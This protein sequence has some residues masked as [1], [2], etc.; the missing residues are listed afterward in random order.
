MWMVELVFLVDAS[1]SVGEQNFA[2]ELRF[3]KKLLADFTVSVNDTRVAVI[4]YASKDQ[5]TVN[6]DHI[7]AASEANHKCSLLQE[8]LPSVRYSGGGTYTLGALL[9]AQAV[10]AGA[11]PTARRA[12]FLVTD[13]FSNGGDPRPA[14]RRLRDSGA[15]VFTFGVRSG[16]TREL[17]DMAT[18]PAA[19]H[20]FLLDGFG[21]FAALAR[22]ALHQDLKPG[23]YVPLGDSSPCDR[24]CVEKRDCCDATASCSCGVDSGHYACVC[25]P[26]H[27]GSGLARSCKAC[28]NGTYSDGSVPGDESVCLPCPDAN[29]VTL[30][31]ATSQQQCRCKEGFV[32]HG[33]RCEVITCPELSP[34]RHGFFVK[35]SCGNVLNAACGARCRVGYRLAGSSIRLCQHDGTW[36][37]EDA[38]CIVKKCPP[39]VLPPNGNMSCSDPDLVVDTE[40]RFACSP[41]HLLVGSKSR[42]CLPLSRWDGLQTICKPLQCPALPQLA[43]GAVSPAA[44][45]AGKQAYGAVC[46]ATCRQGYQLKGPPSRTCGGRAGVWSGKSSNNRCVDATP[47]ELRCPGDIVVGNDPGE[48][49]A[50]VSWSVPNATDNSGHKPVVWSKPSVVP[51]LKM[52]I[53]TTVITYTASDSSKNKAKCNFT[54]TVKDREP[55]AVDQ[56][57]EP[58]PFLTDSA[59][60]ELAWDE[61]QFHDNSGEPVKIRRSPEGD[62]FD[63]GSTLVT[64]TVSDDAGNNSTCSFNVTVEENVCKSPPDL[65]NGHAN[66]SSSPD[67]LHCTLTC[68][69]G[70]AVA[71]Q[72]RDFF[73]TYD[74]AGLVLAPDLEVDPFPDCSVTVLPNSISQDSV[75]TLSGEETLCED[76]GFLSQLEPAMKENIAEKLQQICGSSELV[77]Q[78]GDMKAACDQILSSIE[79]ESNAIPRR[80]RRAVGAGPAVV[81]DTAESNISVTFQI[82]GTASKSQDAGRMLVN[83]IRHVKEALGPALAR[84]GSLQVGPRKRRLRVRHF[85]T[86]GEPRVSCGLGSV[87][88]R[89]K[90]VKCPMGTHH[91]VTSDSCE[92]CGIGEYQP[93]EGEAAC[94]PCPAGSS[95]RKINAKNIRDCRAL[96]PPGC[97][98]RKKRLSLDVPGIKPCAS[99]QLGSYQTLHGQ[100]ACLPCPEN[101]T[102]LRRGAK[103]HSDCKERCPPDSASATGLAPCLA[104]PPGHRQPA[105]GQRTCEDAAGRRVPFSPCFSSPCQRGGTCRALGRQLFACDCPDGYQGSL[106]EEEVDSCE[107]SP[108]LHGGTCSSHGPSYTCSCPPGFTGLS[109]ETDVDECESSPCL[110]GGS[111][112]DSL[113]EYVCLCA[114][115]FQGDR[116]EEDTDECAALPC[117]NE[118]LCVDGVATYSCE[119]LPGFAGAHCEE[120][121]ADPCEVQ[122]CDNGGSCISGYANYSCECPAG[123]S[124]PRC[125]VDVDDCLS[126]PCRHGGQC[127]DLPAGFRCLCD[128]PHSGTLCE[129]EIDTKVV[130]R[131]PSSST[132]DYTILTGPKTSLNQ[133]TL[134]LWLRSADQ[135]NYGTIFSYATKHQ[136]NSFTLTDYNGF[137][138]YVNGQRVITDIAANDGWWHFVCV[139]WDSA[140]GDWALYMDGFLGDWGSGL[141]NGTAIPA[142]GTLVL[143]QEQ[144]R[145]GG[146]FSEA[147]S[148]TGLMASVSLWDRAL[149]PGRVGE[150]ASDCPATDGGSVLSWA[151]F[152]S[153]LTGNLQVENSS[154]CS[155]CPAPGAPARGSV[156]VQ[157]G[158]AVYRCD[159]GFSLLWEGEQV[160]ELRRRCLKQGA[161]E[162]E[163]PVCRRVSCGFP[164]YIAHGF[165]RGRSYLHGD[166]VQY[167]CR[168]GYTLVGSA[169]R[170]CGANG[171]WSDVAPK[172]QGKTCGALRAPAG[173]RLQLLGDDQ[174]SVPQYGHQAEVWCDAGYR[175]LGPSLLSCLRSGHWDYPVPACQPT[176]CRDPPSIIHGFIVADN[177]SSQ[178]GDH[179]KTASKLY[180]VRQTAQYGC[181][182]GYRLEEADTPLVCRRLGVWGGA[183]PACSPVLCPALPELRDG[184]A[185]LLRPSEDNATATADRAFGAAVELSCNEGFTLEG[186]DVLECLAS[187]EWSSPTPSCTPRLCPELP[188]LHG[189]NIMLLWPFEHNATTMTAHAFGAK[190]EL[191][192]SEGFVING[193]VTLECLASGDW[194]APTPSCV[195]RLCPM[196]SEPHSGFLRVLR[197]PEDNT[198]EMANHA[199]G[200][201]VQLGCDEGFTLEGADTLECLASGE[202]S[203]PAPSC[204]PVLCPALPKLAD[205]HTKPLQSSEGNTSTEAADSAVSAVVEMGC[206]EGFVLEGADTLQCLAS[207]EWSAPAPACTPVTCDPAQLP[208]RADD[209][210][211]VIDVVG[212]RVGSAAVLACRAGLQLAERFGKP[213]D[214]HVTWTCGPGGSWELSNSTDTAAF[215]SDEPVCE[216]EILGCPRP[217]VP[218]NAYL[219]KELPPTQDIL[220]IGATVA[221]KCRLGYRPAGTNQWVCGRDGRWTGVNTTCS[222]VPCPAPVTPAHALPAAAGDTGF[223]YGNMVGHECAPG[224]KPY[225]DMTSR[226]Q[227]SGKWSRVRGRCSRLSCNKPALGSG[228]SILGRSYLFMDKV[229]I[230]CPTGT[231][232]VGEAVLTCQSNGKWSSKPSCEAV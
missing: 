53:G 14:A 195:P 1:S 9:Q 7:S 17:R 101:T 186:A 166:A 112:V 74:E 171:R 61:P 28:P 187:G 69:E 164:G 137:V 210:S 3:V 117:M 156:A 193:A 22:R 47:P 96:C 94:V 142:N 106:C 140:L 39:P 122:P 107:S 100:V 49:H 154:F 229:T 109:C 161:W 160:A 169:V 131:F 126:Q 75:V 119:C 70:Y 202:W 130:L 123:Y 68:Q 85:R 51:P 116:C 177:A 113:N 127:Q 168:A 211:Y 87:F 88:R 222:P 215:D 38:Q 104:C 203:A 214:G 183:P 194:S 190:L 108:C 125:E 34:P 115:G 67:F 42:S 37:G 11:R 178:S 135:F 224:Y 44:C 20:S 21:E 145:P 120:E 209:A 19:L 81:V 200:A 176:M 204:V 136:D 52:K 15:A 199:F 97:Y 149:G 118:G 129:R 60:T 143:G 72:P 89:H 207:G 181:D 92:P 57:E 148:F 138:L 65:I 172:C 80:R 43:H 30:S 159:E 24:L 189:G 66:C 175:L 230:K 184:F 110:N 174:E 40:C 82:K 158:A 216:E 98:G 185:M 182:E 23:R 225:G 76:P 147:E 77:C 12:V 157:G 134:C 208:A 105:A 152:L 206:D 4:T 36:S 121:W 163:E 124:G 73:C 90:C 197:A 196:L 132:T 99:C 151:H 227:A 228:A 232:L 2:S 95:S 27:F 150:L 48:D 165:V 191:G 31:P 198:T 6:V 102:T 35:G 153:G 139:C 223:V 192:C 45:T 205:G 59:P 173:G 32:A 71:V 170:V 29:H 217:K 219:L 141:A 221:V 91:N 231:R 13:G 25:P 26:G 167:R 50:T 179:N 62:L 220:A 146:G 84:S 54:V 111:C 41:G 83:G 64:Y 162:G 16:N 55:P 63:F 78:V 79:E 155:D 213:A 33:N 188:E 5:V 86:V 103:A 226:C 56:C 133:V 58:P 218:D 201:V 18:P 144:D 10:L 180:E 114:D 128:P 212:N 8:Q 93:M 46:S